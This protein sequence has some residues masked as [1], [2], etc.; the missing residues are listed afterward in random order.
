MLYC[1]NWEKHISKVLLILLLPSLPLSEPLNQM[2]AFKCTFLDDDISRFDILATKC[3][4]TYLLKNNTSELT[5]Y[6]RNAG[7]LCSSSCCM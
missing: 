2:T 7:T 3:I 5:S 4:K 1:I 6:F